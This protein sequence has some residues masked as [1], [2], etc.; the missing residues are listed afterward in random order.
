MYNLGMK[1]EAPKNPTVVPKNPIHDKYTIQFAPELTKFIR[2]DGKVKTYRFGD[3][4]DYLQI[5]DKVRLA[6]YQTSQFISNAIIANK[7]YVAFKDIPLKLS[8]HEE[9]G[10]R[11]HLRKVF[12]SYYKYIGREV[13]DSDPFLILS[14]ELID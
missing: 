11:D 8:G 5:G 1:M 10:S 6:E 2:K 9:Y 4:Y 3:K 7:E 12:S 14:F 13:E